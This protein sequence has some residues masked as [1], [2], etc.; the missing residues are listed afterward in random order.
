V[1]RPSFPL[2]FPLAIVAGAVAAFVVSMLMIP[3]MGEDA[4]KTFAGVTTASSLIA[5][6]AAIICTIYT[7]LIGLGVVIYVRNTRR[8]PSLRTALVA[9][10][11]AA[12][13]PV[14]TAPI[15]SYFRN[16]SPSKFDV[17]LVPAL[18]IASAIAT[19]WMFW[20]VGLRGR[21]VA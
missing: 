20:R 18:A 19:A 1:S 14:V 17:I 9:G 15:V 5:W 21:T 4:E 11:L 8:V 16:G 7:L 13:I 12:G 10:V 6:Y 3:V 2:A